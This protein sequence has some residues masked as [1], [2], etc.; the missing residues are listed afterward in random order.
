MFDSDF[1]VD[2]YA[3]DSAG[4]TLYELNNMVRSLIDSSFTRLYWVRAELSEVRQ[5]RGH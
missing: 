5:N 2:S 1:S 3:G 4:M